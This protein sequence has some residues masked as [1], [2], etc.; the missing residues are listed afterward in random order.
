M[1]NKQNLP[2]PLK[3]YG[4]SIF[5]TDADL[6]SY[7]KE[8]DQYFDINAPEAITSEIESSN[9]TFSS[10]VLQ[11][12]NTYAY[13]SFNTFNFNRSEQSKPHRF[14]YSDGERLKSFSDCD[15]EFKQ[16][17]E[18]KG[19]L[20]FYGNDEIVDSRNSLFENNPPKNSVISNEVSESNRV[21]Y[22]K[23]SDKQNNPKLINTSKKQKD[24]DMPNQLIEYGEIEKSIYHYNSENEEH[25]ENGIDIISPNKCFS[26]SSEIADDPKFSKG[27]SRNIRNDRQEATELRHNEYS[28]TNDF[29]D[30]VENINLNISKK[31]NN[32]KES[33]EQLMTRVNK[34]N[35]ENKINTLDEISDKNSASIDQFKKKSEDCIRQCRKFETTSENLVGECINTLSQASVCYANWVCLHSSDI[36]Q[37]DRDLENIQVFIDTS[38]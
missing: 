1:E 16:D 28:L 17:E 21:P 23:S 3:P 9:L 36:K 32:L 30:T 12:S 27:N 24:Y 33:V 29:F 4:E 5:T 2:F 38:E 8:I 14:S 6:L 20:V 19:D 37:I 25:L 10:D 7:N 13:S 15:N 35:F 26:F 31:K 18:L 11:T 22:E 34:S